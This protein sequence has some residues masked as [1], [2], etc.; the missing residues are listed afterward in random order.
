VI[1]F[2]KTNGNLELKEGTEK[3][4]FESNSGASM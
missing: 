2:L 1:L 4:N 3:D